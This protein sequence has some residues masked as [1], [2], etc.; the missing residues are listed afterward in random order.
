MQ[1]VGKHMK[2]LMIEARTDNLDQV[3]AFVDQE[4]EEAGCS[5]KQL[6][7]IDLAVEEIFV[8]IANYAYAPGTGSA[9]V[10]VDAGGD[11]AGAVITFEDSGVPYDPL[12]K[13]DPDVTLAIEEREVG[14]LGIF[15]AKKVMDEM[16]Y[17]YRDGKNILSM[18]KTF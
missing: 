6:M 7:Q 5:M 15:M 13:A 14:G 10:R 1:D 4:L 11:P 9:L 8:N 3:L 12:K 16:A 18:R 2:E 17:E